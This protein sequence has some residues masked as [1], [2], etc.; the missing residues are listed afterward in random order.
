MMFVG[1]RCCSAA[2]QNTKACLQTGGYLMGSVTTAV[3]KFVGRVKF[4]LRNSFI[5]KI[6][7][8]LNGGLRHTMFTLKF[9]TTFALPKS[10]HNQR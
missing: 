3:R 8:C 2:S 7:V 5:T 10:P 9:V 1:I 6:S 4:L